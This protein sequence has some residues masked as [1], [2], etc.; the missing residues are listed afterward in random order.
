VT[1]RGRTAAALLLMLAAPPLLLLLWAHLLRP[2]WPSSD[3]IAVIAAGLAGLAGL[4]SAPW[5]AKAKAAVGVAYTLLAIA[6]LPFL[7]LL[8]VCST[9]DCI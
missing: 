9:G 4:L 2:S 7:G 8:A 5:P 1:A 3:L 6:A